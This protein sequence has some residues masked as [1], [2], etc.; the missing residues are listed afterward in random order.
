MEEGRTLARRGDKGWGHGKGRRAQ[1][2]PSLELVISG[3]WSFLLL[4][5]LPLSPSLEV[6]GCVATLIR[7]GSKGSWSW[8]GE[9][10]I[11]VGEWSRN[12]WVGWIDGREA[13]FDLIHS[14]GYR[15]FLCYHGVREKRIII[16]TYEYKYRL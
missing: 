10:E 3:V 2:D 7:L 11:G 4:L 6:A 16:S 15:H 8:N 1:R 5:L 12:G 9:F 13:N 14:F